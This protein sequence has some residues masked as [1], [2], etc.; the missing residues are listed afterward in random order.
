MTIDRPF[1]FIV[2]NDDTDTRSFLGRVMEP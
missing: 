2:Y 1:I